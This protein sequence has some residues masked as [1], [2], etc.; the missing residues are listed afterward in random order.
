MRGDGDVAL[1]EYVEA[2]LA[3]KDKA[4][5]AALIAVKEENR[6]TEIAAEKRFDLLNELRQ[7]VATKEQLEGVEKL[8]NALKERQD[9]SEGRTSGMSD[10]AKIIVSVITA[11]AA[12]IGIW[13]ATR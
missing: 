9:K 2:L 13:I 6:K 7:G 10:T 5:V 4:L 1:R 8:V 3:E 12:I 11:I